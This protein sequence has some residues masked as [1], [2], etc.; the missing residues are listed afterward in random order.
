M[1][2]RKYLLEYNDLPVHAVRFS[3]QES[4]TAARGVRILKAG[5]CQ[6]L[7]DVHD[8]QSPGKMQGLNRGWMLEDWAGR[9][10]CLAMC[11][12]VVDANKKWVD[13]LRFLV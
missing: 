3:P 12:V 4:R 11:V 8:N 7:Y 10:A 5:Q 2:L 13:I 1:V 9:G 6:R